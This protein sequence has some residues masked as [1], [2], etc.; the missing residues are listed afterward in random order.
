MITVDDN[1][2]QRLSRFLD[3]DGKIMISDDMP[4]DLKSAIRFLNANNV[5]LLSENDASADYEASELTDPEIDSSEFENDPEFA[6]VPEEEDTQEDY[7][8]EENEDVETDD[9]EELF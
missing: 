7:V 2:K 8:I 6:E 1:M 3:S 9:L 5:N 4:D